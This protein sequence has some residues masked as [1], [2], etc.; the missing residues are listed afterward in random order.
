[1]MTIVELGKKSLAVLLVAFL[2]MAMLSA[3]SSDEEEAP[4]PAETDTA[5]GGGG[6][7]GDGLCDG[8]DGE[9][10][11]ECIDEMENEL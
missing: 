3:C 9:A 10:Y 11:D 8:L 4:P 1:M 5:G 6:G 2:A 7:G